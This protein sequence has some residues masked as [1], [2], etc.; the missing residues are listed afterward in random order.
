MNKEELLKL[1]NLPLEELIELS[2]KIT[3]ENFNNEV[4]FLQ[5]YKRQNRKM[6]RKLQILLTKCPQQSK[7]RS[8][9]ALSVEEVKKAAIDAKSNGVQDSVWSHQY[10]T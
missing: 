7:N 5:Y 4:E 6:Q 1:Y 10:K 2:S 9:S 3:K 8:P